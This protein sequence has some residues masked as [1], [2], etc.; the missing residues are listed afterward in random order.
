[1]DESIE[2]NPEMMM[3]DKDILALIH[4][5]EKEHPEQLYIRQTYQH[6]YEGVS[7][8]EIAVLMD[9]PRSTAQGRIART[10][11]FLKQYINDQEAK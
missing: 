11:K 10:L 8:S 9:V 2:A 6:C 1:M 4:R 5:A 3:D 7:L